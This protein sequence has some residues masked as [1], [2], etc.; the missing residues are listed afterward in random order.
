MRPLEVQIKLYKYALN[1]ILQI[2]GNF[3]HGQSYALVSRLSK[4]AYPNHFHHILT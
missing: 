2:T 1:K 3:R 4:I